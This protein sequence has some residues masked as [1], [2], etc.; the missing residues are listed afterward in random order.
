MATGDIASRNSNSSMDLLTQL[1]ATFKGGPTTTQ[2][3]SETVSN[4]KAKAYLE[5]ILGS[6][7]GLAAVSSG[8][9]SA[10]LYNSSVNQQ[11]TN[12]LLSRT[13]A[14]TAALSSTKTATSQV[15]PQADPLMALLALG[16]GQL[17]GS[18]L[19]PAFKTGKKKL[20]LDDLGQKISDSIFGSSSSLATPYNAMVDVYPAAIDNVAINS[21]A[22]QNLDD[23]GNVQSGG[24]ST[25]SILGASAGAAGFAELAGTGTAAT[26]GGYV[27]GAEGATW[28]AADTAATTGTTALTATATTAAA[29]GAEVA[30]T[31][32]AATG[33]ESLALAVPYVAA[34]YAISEGSKA[35]GIKEVPH[36]IICTELNR[37]GRMP[38][39]FYRYGGR[40]FLKYDEHGKQ[41]YYIWAIPSVRHLR[42]YPTSVYSKLLEIVFN[43]RA[44]YLSAIG[45]CTGA[46]KTALGFITTHCLYVGCWILSRTI[47]RKPVTNSQILGA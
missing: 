6:A 16:G 7:G 4:D 47:A 15:G 34:A 36:W 22:L 27:V 20:G 14:Q 26:G 30:G 31:A 44:E 24:S 18:L 9:K 40:E 12:D 32:A 38:H 45:G 10:G 39:N 1:L 41:G 2:T 33:A 13:A 28:L 25:G 46:R 8:Q 21:A 5:Q 17:A 29:T 11:L 19:G 23:L 35:L 37:Q 43:A 42:K 3:S